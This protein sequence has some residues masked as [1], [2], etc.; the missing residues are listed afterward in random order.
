MA[1]F[2]KVEGWN[3]PVDMRVQ[4]QTTPD[5]APF[6]VATVGDLKEIE[7]RVMTPVIRSVARNVIGGGI[8]DVE[9]VLSKEETIQQ[10][11]ITRDGEDRDTTQTQQ[12]STKKVK[13]RI[14]VLDLQEN[15]SLIEDKIEEIIRPEGEKA[16]MEI[17]DV[18]IGEPAIPPELLVARRREQLAGQMVKAFQEEKLAQDQRIE[19]EKSKATAEQQPILVAAEIEVEASEKRKQS[20]ENQGEGEKAN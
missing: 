13:R 19:T 20:L 4:V 9:E 12:L 8:I 3:V 2:C 5:N 1:I 14:E 18:R 16:Y 10:E 7:D 11:S 15:R 17:I 6:V